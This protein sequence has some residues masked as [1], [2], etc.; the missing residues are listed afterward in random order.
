MNFAGN[1]LLSQSYGVILLAN[2]GII[3]I[4]ALISVYSFV[5]LI[6]MTKKYNKFMR[7]LGDGN[8][9]QLIE[10]CLDNVQDVK[11]KNKEIQNKI[12]Y[13]ERNLYHCVQKVGVIR[14]N[15]FENVGSDLS[16]AIALL[17]S[18]DNGVVLS[19]VYSRDNSISYAK[20]IETGRSRYSL[21]AEE[22]QAIDKAKRTHGERVYTEH[23]IG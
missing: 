6:S 13:L 15:A 22:I 14:Y 3:I 16:Y 8:L 9:E 7:G 10:I 18:S 5:K 12:N 23:K 11:L 17:D 19:G 4:L 20:I 1:E 2:S 21:S